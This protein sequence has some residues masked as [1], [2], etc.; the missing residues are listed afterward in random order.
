M[1]VVRQDGVWWVADGVLERVG[2]GDGREEKVKRG[3]GSKFVV[4]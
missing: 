1:V 4:K 3:L 2:K